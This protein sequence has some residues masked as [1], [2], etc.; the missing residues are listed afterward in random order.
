MSHV[1]KR[2]PSNKKH[3]SEHFDDDETVYMRLSTSVFN[4][5]ESSYDIIEFI[6]ITAYL[7]CEYIFE[8]IELRNTTRTRIHIY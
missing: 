3:I 6:Y 1:Y 5:T 4:A 8:I 7:N 2:M